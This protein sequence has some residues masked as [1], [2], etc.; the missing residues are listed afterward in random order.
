MN[1]EGKNIREEELTIGNL[2]AGRQGKQLANE[3]AAEQ[4]PTLNTQPQTSDR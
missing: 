3:P 2:T 4:T 1:E